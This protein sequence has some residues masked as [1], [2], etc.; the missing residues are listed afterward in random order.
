MCR[1]DRFDEAVAAFERELAVTPDHAPSIAEIGT[2]LA[3]TGRT[4]AA[5]P[6]LQRA[7]GL[8]PGLVPAQYSLG[9]ALLTE[10]RRGE[11]IRA[12]DRA[13]A[14]DGAYADAYRARG[15]AFV[16]DGQFE[17]SVED[18]HVA[19]A[20]NSE[21]YKAIID[22]G[23]SFGRAE[24]SLQSGKL[25]EMAARVAPDIALAQ[26]FFGQFL[27][28]QRQYERGLHHI[29][30]AL[31]LDPLHAES[32]VGRGFG[33]LGQGRI[34][35]AVQAYRRGGELKP[36]DAVI[37]G[38]LLFALQH[39]PSVTEAE[40]FQAHRR[41]GALY[42]KGDA[43]NDRR[44]FPNPP[45]PER[46]PRI[47]IVSPDMH[48]HAVAFLTLRAF[49]DLAAQGFEIVCF[50]TLRTRQ[51]DEYSERFK[52]A[53]TAWH[54]IF[55]LDD[56]AAM[57]LIAEEG[58]D[59]LFDLAGHTAG[60]RISVFARRA[61]PIQLS[62]A[63][64]VGTI[65]LDTYDGII[66]DPVEI[67]PGHDHH[68]VEP[69]IRL[70][71]CYVCYDPPPK[72]PA[73]TPLPCLQEGHVTFGCFNR[74]A[75][76][77]S[78]LAAVWARI[79]DAVPGSRLLMVY[80]GLGE[81]S[82][83]ESVL[84]I[85]EDGGLD[86]ARVDLVGRT[87]QAELL[88]AYGRVD[89]ALDPFPYSGGV[90]TLEAMWMGVPTVTLVGE[91]FAGRHSASHLTAAGLDQFCTR[92]ADDYV[93]CA[94]D[95]TQRPEALAALRATLRAQ[96]AAS[97]LMDARGFGRDLAEALEQQWRGWCAARSIFTEA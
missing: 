33:L 63:G 18:L 89:L 12:F 28:N 21:N 16:M 55:D 71:N 52:A 91:T 29:D 84:R 31:E 48:R 78:V 72:P 35:E 95:W 97:P 93:A 68:Y 80:G 8:M 17:R 60:T 26:Y 73:V 40:L 64:Y 79:L 25:F 57:K 13:I 74:P 41:W 85:L 23:V 38:T 9:L 42:R 32:H 65:G 4:A 39:K 69:V 10:D 46:R 15:L 44:H 34:E 19:A 50:K 83:R 90:T 77:N 24:R 92:T 3:R 36:E 2:C 27:I 67:P 30:R 51:D 22:L 76:I 88:E 66:A 56:E 6:Y 94:V 49:E 70:P 61:A 87:E 37:A 47:G 62:W 43:A 54:E 1:F 14:L 82:T 75:K 45:D 5:I 11:A 96:L 58:I 81:A 20:I 7:V 59:I 86:G 53:A